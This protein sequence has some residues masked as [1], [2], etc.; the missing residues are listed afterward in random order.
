MKFGVTEKKQLELEARMASCGLFESDIE[1]SFIRSPGPGGQHANKT[2]TAVRLLHKPH[3][4][5]RTRITNRPRQ[6]TPQS[7]RSKNQKTKAPPKKK[8][9][10]QLSINFSMLPNGQIGL[11]S[12]ILFFDG[13]FVMRP[14]VESPL[15]FHNGIIIIG[16]M[17]TGLGGE[18]TNL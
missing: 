1:E 17:L 6:I 9:K 2:S 15:K 13:H 18:M 16:E 10:I 5:R 7:R 3:A 11:K 4:L 14:A 12:Y 8:I